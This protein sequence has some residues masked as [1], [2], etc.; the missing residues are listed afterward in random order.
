VEPGVDADGADL[1][2]GAE[3]QLRVFERRGVGL[4]PGQQEVA[5]CSSPPGRVL[6]I[7]ALQPR[8]RGP[9]RVQPLGAHRLVVDHAL[10]VE[11]D[12]LVARL[13]SGGGLAA[14][15]EM[16]TLAAR[17]TSATCRIQLVA[18]TLSSMFLLEQE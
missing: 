15:R 4:R 12:V 5:R 2:A 17:E 7:G 6:R 11:H 16:S 8:V 14:T 18:S 10:E 9:Q 13:A 3:R 1:G